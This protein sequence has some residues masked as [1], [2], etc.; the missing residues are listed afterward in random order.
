MLSSHCKRA[1]KTVLLVAACLAA[2][3]AQGAIFRVR[4]SP[5]PQVQLTIGSG[6]SNISE[7]RFNVPSGQ[8]GNGNPIR[9]NPPIRVVLANRAT[10]NFS[11]TAVLTVDS[12]TP[13]TNGSATL[14]F[15]EISWTSRDGDVPAGRYDGSNNQFLLS[16]PNS[17]LIRDFHRFSY[18]NTSI[19]EAGTYT[20]RVTYTLSMP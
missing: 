6:G 20:G 10:P 16:F 13:L 2:W 8:L 14:P 7:V 11:R 4:N 19:L 17:F 1:L 9:G 15:T 12:S 18:D 3:P 5:P